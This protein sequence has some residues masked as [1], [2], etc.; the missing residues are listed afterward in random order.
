MYEI[1]KCNL[2]LSTIKYVHISFSS[3][4]VLSL[5][6]PRFFF[7]LNNIFEFSR[8]F[9]R[10]LKFTDLVNLICQ[11]CV[12]KSTLLNI[13]KG[14]SEQLHLEINAFFAFL[15]L[16]SRNAR[17]QFLAKILPCQLKTCKLKSF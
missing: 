8:L 7:K 10:Q 6:S 3:P 5:S 2:E 1:T 13:L 4:L 15:R 16:L 17:G 14:L 12:I 9:S 11:L